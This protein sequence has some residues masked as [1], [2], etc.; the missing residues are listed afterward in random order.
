MNSDR[1]QCEQPTNVQS[2]VS[3]DFKGTYQIPSIQKNIMAL[4][5]NQGYESTSG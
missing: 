4:N 2:E 5:C 3:L 1:N